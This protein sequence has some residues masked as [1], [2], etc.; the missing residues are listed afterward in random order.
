MIL[1]EGQKTLHI[2][3][4]HDQNLHTNFHTFSIYFFID[5]FR[6]NVP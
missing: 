3:K 6:F 5:K 4:N 1:L 2:P